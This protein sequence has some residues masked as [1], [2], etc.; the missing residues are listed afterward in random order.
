[1]AT[2]EIMILIVTGMA[3]LMIGFMG[4]SDYGCHQTRFTDNNWCKTL[5]ILSMSALPILLIIHVYLNVKMNKWI[6]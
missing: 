2:L 6:F 1:M 5:L 4:I 3:F